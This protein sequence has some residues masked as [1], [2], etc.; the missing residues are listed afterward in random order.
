MHTQGYYLVNGISYTD[1]ITA[2]L[3]A[4][5]TL[6]D[7]SWNY[8]RDVFDK[9]NWRIEPQLSL[10]SLYRIRAQQIRDKYDYV[11]VLVSGGADST[12]MVKSFLNNNIHIDEIVASHAD[13]GLS[14]WQWN[15]KDKSINN[16]I[17]ETKYAQYPL[18]N[19]ISVKYPNVKI[20]IKDY[21][22]DILN[23]KSD[24]WLLKSGDWISPVNT[25]GK[26]DK[27]KH[28][29]NLA[30]QGKRIAVCW[31]LD[32]PNL[33]YSKEGDIYA[34]I[35]DKGVNVARPAFDIDYP[36]VDKV[37]FYWSPELPELII[38]G[39]H[40]V[41]KYVHKKENLWITNIIKEMGNF[42]TKTV[43]EIE[44]DS[45]GVPVVDNKPSS[46]GEYQRAIVPCL[47]PTTWNNA[48]QCDKG[49]SSFMGLQNDWFY[50]LHKDT[51]AY[52]MIESDFK[53]FYKNLNPKYL[54]P[55]RTGFKPLSQFYKLG[56]Y[57]QFLDQ[58]KKNPGGGLF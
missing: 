27:F 46:K 13:S 33:R 22:E 35:T 16:T 15:D 52:Q 38:K 39:A 8:Y 53:N 29:V 45:F 2:I 26:L 11:V 51:M 31:G 32:K 7:I 41:A 36:N 57:K 25:K 42:N 47:Y 23:F 19:E 20:S 34:L 9:I 44:Q 48:F 50:K 37:L 54:H 17:S 1:K 5:K 24:E 6:A 4:Q 55:S 3:E 40:E 21:F 14:K 18:L 58:S 43:P 28:I 56:H 30:E 49:N 10:D 12:N